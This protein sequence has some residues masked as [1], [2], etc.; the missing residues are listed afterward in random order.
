MWYICQSNLVCVY[1]TYYCL[2]SFFNAWSPSRVKN[3]HSFH[4]IFIS[5]SL[6]WS[7]MLWL[8]LFLSFLYFF[9][10][11]IIRFMSTFIRLRGNTMLNIRSCLLPI[12]N[13]TRVHV[14]VIEHVQYRCS[15]VYLEWLILIKEWMFILF[16]GFPFVI[17]KRMR[18]AINDHNGYYARI[19]PLLIIFIPKYE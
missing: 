13:R 16:R 8:L 3:P 14:V 12:L 19:H 18:Y 15:C 7:D 11:I 6:I 5:T 4:L 17:R 2:S 1:I 9:F 10:L